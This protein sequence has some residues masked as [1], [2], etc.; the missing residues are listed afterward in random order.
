MT[1]DATTARTLIVGVG[2]TGR[3]LL[4]VLGTDA[5]GLSRSGGDHGTHRYDLD[6]DSP[7]PV[8]IAKATAIVYTV[9]PA[10]DDDGRLDALLSS[11]SVP[12]SRF[13]YLSTTGVYGDH[14]GELVDES[15]PAA[16]ATDRARHRVAAER[17]LERWARE[18]DVTLVVLRVPGIY[19][20]GRLGLDRIRERLPVIDDSEAGPGNRIHVDDLVSAIR[21][22]LDAGTPAGV[23]NVG[24]GDNRSATAF[25]A[26]VARQ[27]G[28]DMPPR[29]SM[30][31]ARQT[32]SPM[33]LSFLK[34]S[35]RLDL[36]RMQTVLKPVLRYTDAADGIAAALAEERAGAR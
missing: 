26:E 35:R 27:A 32:F 24:D 25:T 3:R 36:T 17:R 5:L 6:A 15:M 11:L 7:E 8:V 33:R 23:Y 12:P 22:A 4:A 30:R 10:G 31:E 16:P 9:P 19:G 20:P 1:I 14:R 28:L 21:A 2:Y 29:I 34:E 13:V 18:H